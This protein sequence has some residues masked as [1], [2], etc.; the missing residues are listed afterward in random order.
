MRILVLLA[1]NL[2]LVA[3]TAIA[4]SDDCDAI[5]KIDGQKEYNRILCVAIEYLERNEY[6]KAVSALEKAS[7]IRMHE[8]PNFLIYPRLAVAYASSGQLKEARR[9]LEKA[10][11]TL[12]VYFGIFMCRHSEDDFYLVDRAERRVEEDYADYAIRK[13]CGAAYEYIYEQQAL[14]DILRESKYIE[15]FLSATEKVNALDP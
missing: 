7:V 13:M 8:T 12:S 10:E 11:I 9:T 3:N 5:E 1:M 2:A 4:G 15:H 14:G 6:D